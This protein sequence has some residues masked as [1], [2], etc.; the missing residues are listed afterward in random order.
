VFNKELITLKDIIWIIQK[1][2][3]SNIEKVRELIGENEEITSQPQFVQ[4]FRK[5]NFI[6]NNLDRLEVR[7]RDSAGL[8]IMV[9]FPDAMAFQAFFKTQ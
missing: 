4:E 9:T 1:E 6:L 3:L 2:C 8:S 7:G 5:V